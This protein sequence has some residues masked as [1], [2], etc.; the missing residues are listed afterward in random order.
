MGNC[1]KKSTKF[2]IMIPN[3]VVRHIFDFLTVCKSCHKHN[4]FLEMNSCCLCG[5]FWCKNKCSG[6]ILKSAYFEI[7]VIICKSCFNKLMNSY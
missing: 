6:E 4:L 7:S 3:D 5:N 1:L 2:T